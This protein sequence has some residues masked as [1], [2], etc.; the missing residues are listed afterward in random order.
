MSMYPGSLPQRG[1]PFIKVPMANEEFA[2]LRNLI[3]RFEVSCLEV[4]MDA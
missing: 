1:H 3:L 2:E 4:V